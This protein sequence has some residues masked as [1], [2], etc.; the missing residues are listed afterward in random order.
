MLVRPRFSF[1]STVYR[2]FQHVEEIMNDVFFAVLPRANIPG[3]GCLC[4]SIILDAPLTR[5]QQVRFF[6]ETSRTDWNSPPEILLRH[7]HIR[8][9]II[10]H[11]VEN[12]PIAN[13][14]HPAVCA[15]YLFQN[16]AGDTG[17]VSG[18]SGIF[19]KD[20]SLSGHE[21]VDDSVSCRLFGLAT[22]KIQAQSP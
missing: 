6:L 20:D 21:G 3:R 7:A 12:M 18:S 2:D 14:R 11:D 5:Q 22:H 17:K 1:S 13:V 4:R 9:S 8:E 16:F 10:K 19:R 15:R